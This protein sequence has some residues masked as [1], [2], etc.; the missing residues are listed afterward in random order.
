LGIVWRLV[1]FLVAG[2]LFSFP[3]AASAQPAEYRSGLIALRAGRYREA[4]ALL[5]NALSQKPSSEYAY[6]PYYHLGKAY[7]CLDDDAKAQQYFEQSFIFSEL[8]TEREMVQALDQQLT[9]NPPPCNQIPIQRISTPSTSTT[10]SVRPTLPTTTTTT[11]TND[12][13]PKAV[14]DVRGLLAQSRIQAALEILE[15]SDLPPRSPDR[16]MMEQEIRR[17]GYEKAREGVRK[18]FRGQREDAISDLEDARG[19]L[20]DRA[21]FHLFLAL[22]YHG[23]YLYQSERD[24]DLLKKM[25]LSIQDA[26]ELDRNVEV[27][28][29]LFSPVIREAIVRLRDRP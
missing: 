18:I 20:R 4:A 15:R 29:R 14:S 7:R 6:Y 11:A 1:I 27:D 13:A 26:L 19:A 28:P 16:V 22:A 5:E 17:Y 3:T 12:V 2:A 9:L 25:D 8:G 24:P 21:L 23:A 10:T